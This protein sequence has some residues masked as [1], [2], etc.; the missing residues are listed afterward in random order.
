MSSKLVGYRGAYQ[1]QVQ[2]MAMNG[3]AVRVAA[4]V[5]PSAAV[6]F[7]LM[8]L[9]V[10][11]AGCGGKGADRIIPL[12]GSTPAIDTSQW[13]ADAPSPTELQAELKRVL[14]ELGVDTAK[15]VAK[16]PTGTGNAVF[17]LDAV[18]I[19]PDGEGGEPPTGVALSWTER[20]LGDYNQDGLVTVNDLAPLGQR[21]QDSVAYD[22][23]ALHGGYAQ[24]PAGDPTDDGGSTPPAPGSGAENWRLARIDGNGNG[25][26]EIQD[27]TQMGQHWGESLDGYIIERAVNFGAGELVWDAA[28]LDIGYGREPSV[29]RSMAASGVGVG[30]E[31]SWPVRYSMLVSLT[32]AEYSQVFRVRAYDGGTQQSSIES[33]LVHYYPT[34]ASD[35]TPPVWVDTV[36]V[37]HLDPG[38]EQLTVHFGVAEDGQS[39][40]V[41]YRV[42]WAE[43]DPEQ[44]DAPFDYESAGFADANGAPYTISGLANDQYY[45]VSVRAMDSAT[46][47][48]MELNTVVLGE[49][50]TSSDVYP[51]DWNGEPGIQDLFF[52]NGTAVI[53][54]EAATDHYEQGE[55][56]WESGPPVYRVYYGQGTEV[57][58]DAANVAEFDD[59][60]IPYY[61][62]PINGLDTTQPHWFAVRVR[63]QADLP[64]EDGNTVTL[65]SSG[66]QVDQ[67]PFPD[68]NPP[69]PSDSELAYSEIVTDHAMSQAKFIE[70]WCAPDLTFWL[71]CWWVKSTGLVHDFDFEIGMGNQG[72]GDFLFSSAMLNQNGDLSMLF[73][74][75]PPPFKS[76][77]KLFCQEEMQITDLDIGDLN[78]EPVTGFDPQMRPWAILIDWIQA[79]LFV[80]EYRLYWSYLPSSELHEFWYQP[81]SDT[82]NKPLIQ[83]GAVCL[84]DGHILLNILGGGLEGYNVLSFDGS[85]VEILDG[86]NSGIE[87]T[88]YRGVYGST[89]QHPVYRYDST[90]TNR[91][92]FLRQQDRELA[93]SNHPAWEPANFSNI[94][95]K[96]LDRMAMQ[97]WFITYNWY[98]EPGFEHTF[99][100]FYATK[101]SSVLKIPFGAPSGHDSWAFSKLRIGG[102]NRLIYIGL[103]TDSDSSDLYV[104]SCMY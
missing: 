34:S 48:N 24:W 75:A 35:T 92:Y 54:W 6:L 3:M 57:D 12:A 10:S 42:Y 41:K 17:D 60:E 97:A 47:A 72:K 80:F 65:S 98:P 36:G 58:F 94:C 5:V 101:N 30:T 20:L 89:V 96:N 53:V 7:L 37:A 86:P 66:I 23:P 27:I 67:F 59:I 69:I 31:A 90:E 51:P 93:I 32:D 45:R 39:P 13:R 77:P 71:S 11:A 16:A 82:T 64:N 61:I 83:S 28:P 103:I 91:L 87:G 73:Q 78:M 44:P 55:M 68:V 4:K 52:G 79:S 21:W 56:S 25:I 63:D 8:V 43:G 95:V 29:P 62:A 81:P 1:R 102:V 88:I 49:K 50:P 99:S 40:P 18:V 14:A 9:C 100:A 70:V 33:N 22:A 104:F 85:S 19:D 74:L 46:P 38:F 26:V 84:D 2:C 15:A 76:E